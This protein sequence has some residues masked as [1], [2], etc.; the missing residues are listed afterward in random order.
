MTQTSKA[1]RSSGSTRAAKPVRQ[2]QRVALIAGATGLLGREVLARI[3]DSPLYESTHLLSRRELRDTPDTV[4]VHVVDFTRL[5]PLP[6]TDDV[7]ICLGTTIRQAGS[8][9]AFR[10]VDLDAVVAVAKGARAAGAKRLAVVSALGAD[11]RSMVFYNR[12]KGEMEAALAGLGY[13]SVVIVRPSLL[14]GDR[15][16]LGQPVRLGEQISLALL[17]PWSGLIPKRVRPIAAQDVAR[18]MVAG[19][20][21]P[22]AGVRVIESGEMQA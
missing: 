18:A 19:L 12:V 22:A 15:G 1:A 13:E 20:A 7:Y 2:A 21:E 14:A 5:P 3:A 11:A 17:R 6:T 9:A 16:S 4:D 10:A 8:E